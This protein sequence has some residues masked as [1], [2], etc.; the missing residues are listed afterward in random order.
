MVCAV[1]YF[2]EAM[3]GAK[4]L[5][6]G[7]PFDKILHLFN[8]VRGVQIFGA[9]FEIAGPVFHFVSGSRAKSG[10]TKG[11]AAIVENSLRNCL[12]SMLKPNCHSRS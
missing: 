4:Y 11:P 8:R 1:G 9:V 12:L 6:F 3:A 5:K 2:V 7:L 10:E